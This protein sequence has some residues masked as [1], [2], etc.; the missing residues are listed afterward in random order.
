MPE[1]IENKLE[2]YINRRVQ[3]EETKYYV[4]DMKQSEMLSN[5]IKEQPSHW[6]NQTTNNG[7]TLYLYSAYYV[8]TNTQPQPSETDYILKLQNNFLFIS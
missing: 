7:A 4:E 3:Q 2:A 1:T 6:I 8:C 5:S